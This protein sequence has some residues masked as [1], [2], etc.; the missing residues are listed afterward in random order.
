VL[1]VSK[2]CLLLGTLPLL[3]AFPLRA[4]TGSGY[5]QQITV[6][7]YDDVG[8]STSAM[9]QAE[10]KSAR[11]FANAGLNVVWKNCSSSTSDIGEDALV[12]GGEPS[13]PGSVF[14][15]AAG[16]IQL[17]GWEHQPLLRALRTVAGSSGRPASRFASCANPDTGPT[18][19]SA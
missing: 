5:N 12:R 2:T 13:S 15:K 14:E 16:L 9:A 1:C 4:Q 10:H 6:S 7:V 11:I 3:Y 18:K 8:I 19:S 17:G